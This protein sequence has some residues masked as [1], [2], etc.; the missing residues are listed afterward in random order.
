MCRPRINKER[1]LTGGENARKAKLW[2][3]RLSA[4]EG[5]AVG[6]MGAV[7]WAFLHAERPSAASS[8]GREPL[9][10]EYLL[11]LSLARW[12]PSLPWFSSPPVFG[13]Q[14]HPLSFWNASTWLLRPMR[15]TSSPSL[16]RRRLRRTKLL[17]SFV[18]S[19]AC[20][21]GPPVSRQDFVIS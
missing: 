6:A 7:P 10:W 15:G 16:R 2:V 19:I 14:C 9:A 8:T 18:H 20:I 4:Q 17:L 13:S 5:H 12:G 11:G 1:V 21:C 3:W